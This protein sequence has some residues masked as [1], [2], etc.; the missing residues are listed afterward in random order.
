MLY[1][2]FPVGVVCCILY[3]ILDQP[4]PYKS[5]YLGHGKNRL[6]VFTRT[7]L[8]SNMYLFPIIIGDHTDVLGGMINHSEEPNTTVVKNKDRY[9]LFTIKNIGEASELTVNYNTLPEWGIRINNSW[10]YV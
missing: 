7:N 10:V 9:N 2:L 6:G 1:M 3:R 8:D 4:D 5:L